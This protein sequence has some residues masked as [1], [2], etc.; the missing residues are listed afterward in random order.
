MRDKDEQ[1]NAIWAWAKCLSELI[2]WAREPD[3][4]TTTRDGWREAFRIDIRDKG[5]RAR[6]LAPDPETRNKVMRTRSLACDVVRMLNTCPDLNA[7]PCRQWP[8]TERHIVDELEDHNKTFVALGGGEQRAE[9]VT[10]TSGTTPEAAN[11]SSWPVGNGW[12]FRPGEAAFQGKP[13]K[14]TG[15]PVVILRR[16]AVKP[17]EPVLKSVLW[18]IIDPDSNAEEG[19]V[20]DSITEARAILRKAFKLGKKVNPIPNLARGPDAAWKLAE[21]VLCVATKNPR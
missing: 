8:A 14:I 5:D 19:C 20:R 17:G 3:A 10:M 1:S 7:V 12:E 18:D 9:P 15:K 2:F 21:D 13:F 6:D 11:G 16:L 4:E